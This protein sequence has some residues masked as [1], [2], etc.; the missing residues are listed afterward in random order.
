MEIALL[1]VSVL[2]GGLALAAVVIAAIMEVIEGHD[3]RQHGW[4]QG[5]HRS[6]WLRHGA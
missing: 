1:T 2:L 5:H 4:V 3:I 6:H